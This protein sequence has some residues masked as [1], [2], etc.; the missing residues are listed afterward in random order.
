[1][2]GHL[3]SSLK[4]LKKTPALNP[5]RCKAVLCVPSL[6]IRTHV[7]PVPCSGFGSPLTVSTG[8]AGPVE[9]PKDAPPL[10]PL[11]QL[12]GR[13]RGHEPAA[14]AAAAG[15]EP[16]GITAPAGATAS[17]AQPA[18]QDAVPAGTAAPAAAAEPGGAADMEADVQ[19][20]VGSDTAGAPGEKGSGAEL[21]SR[22]GPGGAGAPAPA[23]GLPGGAAA[24]AVPQGNA[25][26]PE[27]SPDGASSD[28]VGDEVCSC[29]AAFVVC[30]ILPEH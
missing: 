29:L 10:V 13:Q 18:A 27:D 6:V 20:P 5:V 8:A 1:M 2:L 4:H 17:S 24:P 19:E 26:V 9:P 21:G 15:T 3:S 23:A 11:R 14:A 28:A 16:H 30:C 22:D 25:E 7:I 12:L